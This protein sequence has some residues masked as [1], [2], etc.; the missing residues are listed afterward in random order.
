MGRKSRVSPTEAHARDRAVRAAIGQMLC[1]Q[2]ELAEPLPVRLQEL[3]RQL[4]NAEERA[5]A[6]TSAY[7][8]STGREADGL[9]PKQ[10]LASE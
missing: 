10:E 8:S 9:D 6:E 5:V 3:L 4:E 1:A 7:L 2:Y